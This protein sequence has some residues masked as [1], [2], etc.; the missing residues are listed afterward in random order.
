M[1]LGSVIHSTFSV[2]RTYPTT[3]EKVFAAFADPAKK[4]RWMVEGE[5]FVTDEFTMDFRVG[6]IERARFR[7]VGGP[8]QEDTPMGNDTWY[9]DI[10]PGRRIVVAY[11]MTVAGNR[12]STSLATFEFIGLNGS[13]QL[14]YTEQAAFFEGSD[15]S[16]MRQMGWN[17]L[18][19]ALA[20]EL[21]RP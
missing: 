15:G 21:S 2:E 4:R 12:I 13:T 6:G 5:G 3:P 20:K 1:Q 19:D 8:L 17:Q 18:M 14:R 16:E 10:V 9:H 11:D 7:A